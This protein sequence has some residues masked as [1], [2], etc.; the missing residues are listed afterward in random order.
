MRYPKDHKAK[1]R[2]KILE[3]AGRV[4][5]RLGY[6]GGGVDAVMREA[7]LTHGGFYAHFRNKEALFAEVVPAAM[8]AMTLWRTPLPEGS[9]GE[10]GLASE[11][12]G[13]TWLRT[14]SD[15][16]LS[17]HHRGATESGCPVPTLVSEL[18]RAGEP[19]REAFGKALEDWRDQL[20]PHFSHLP[21][22]Q[23]DEAALALLIHCVGALSLAR[24]V[25]DGDLSD[26]LLAA[27]RA[28]LGRAYLDPP[29]A[30]V[31]ETPEET[32]PRPEIPSPS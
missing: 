29:T 28:S 20:S 24:A 25:G 5:R 16:Y 11:D 17:N 23:R 9:E 21:E 8:K 19:P 10:E 6:Q 14:V 12:V 31:P 13:R 4:F 32:P 26:A 18:G 2:G 3:A 1:T 22:E 30:P 27:G 15:R 7:G